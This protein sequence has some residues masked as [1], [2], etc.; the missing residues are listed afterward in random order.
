MNYENCIKALTSKDKFY[1]NLGLDRISEILK[2][3]GNP[4][5][6]IKCIQVA[7]TNG[8]G[9]VC[10]ILDSVLKEAGYK[11]GLYSSPHIFDYTERISVNGVNIDKE[12]FSSYYEKINSL[13]ENNGIH[14]TE[15][16]VLTAIMFNYFYDKK[17][18]VAIIETGLGGRFD[19]TNVVK[20]NICSV[21]THIDLDHTDRLGK[22]KEEIAFE[23]AGIIK[24]NSPVYTNEDY[25]TIVRK[26]TEV[27]SE[28]IPPTDNIPLEYINALALKGVHQEKNLALALSVIRNIFNISDKNVI[29]NGL[30]QVKNPCRFQYIKRKNLLIDGAHNPDCFKVLMENL[31]KYFPDIKRNYIFGCLNTK[32][33]KKMLGFLEKDKNMNKLYVYKFKNPNSCDYE[34]IQKVLKIQ[35]QELT[36][37]VENISEKGILTVICGSFYMINELVDKETIINCR[38]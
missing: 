28:I 24:E 31:D 27:K 29:L 32:D 22:T 38:I 4:Q 12:E 6:S 26:A 16:E 20:T 25:D 2:L 19:A 23:K 37:S 34:T 13:A 14:L 10:A 17:V 8:K 9:S 35:A 5:D 33:Y 18:D 30:K 7:G 36:T 15:F 21:I 11:T 3:S 1:I